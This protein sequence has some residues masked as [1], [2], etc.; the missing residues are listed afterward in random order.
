MKVGISQIVLGSSTLEE[1]LDL[2]QAAGYE[3]VELVFAP[4]KDLDVNSS[5]SKLAGTKKACDAA[6]VE[7]T[8]VLVQMPAN[9][10]LLSL[11][12]RERQLRCS[13]VV[14]AL[15]IAEGLQAGAVLLNPGQLDPGGTYDEAW[16]YAMEALRGLAG[17]AEKKQ[18]AICLENVWNKFL[19]SPKEM[20]QFVDEVASEWFGVYLD[21]ANM[22][23]YG[24][25][26]QWVRALGSRIKRVHL[27]DYARK[28]RSFVNLLDGDTDW[29]V[30][31]SE[32]RKTGY[33]S[34]LLHEIAGGREELIDLGDRMRRILE[35]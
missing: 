18:T 15:E 8:S 6:G 12:P 26:E 11:D 31:I 10:N 4:S 7:I 22:M 3:A 13:S 23:E 9:G 19:L 28:S 5:A 14:R 21:T 27:K 17:D 33:D 32:L 1:T 16:E 29:P 24:Y 2:C 25:P 34:A 30:V 20:S 35:L